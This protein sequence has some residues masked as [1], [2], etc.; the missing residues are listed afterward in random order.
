MHR[1]EVCLRQILRVSWTEWVL[2]T[3]AVGRSV[4]ALM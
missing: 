3:A 4:L 1:N 2:E